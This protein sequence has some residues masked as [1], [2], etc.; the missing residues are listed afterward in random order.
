[1]EPF[2]KESIKTAGGGFVV[3]IL[4]ALLSFGIP[5][6]AL[7]LYAATFTIV[8]LINKAQRAEMEKDAAILKVWGLNKP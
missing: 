6:I 8:Y 4:P 5:P 7:I 3:L 2:W 1:M